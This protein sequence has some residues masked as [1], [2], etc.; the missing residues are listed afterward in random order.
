[1]NGE[2]EV[3]SN[4]LTNC[5]RYAADYSICLECQPGYYISGGSCSQ[6]SGCILCTTAFICLT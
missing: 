2:C 6:C 3:N 4:G 1:M 5:V